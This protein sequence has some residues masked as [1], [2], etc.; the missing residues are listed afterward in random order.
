MYR[1]GVFYCTLKM[2]TDNKMLL[3]AVSFMKKELYKECLF[4]FN[5]NLSG[6]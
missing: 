5:N 2:Q 4:S 6:F 1:Q 3:P